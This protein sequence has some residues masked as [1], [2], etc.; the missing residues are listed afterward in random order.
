MTY[1]NGNQHASL[2]PCGPM[3]QAWESDTILLRTNNHQVG[4][5]TMRKE[6]G[7]EVCSWT[8][9]HYDGT[10]F[11]VIQTF[12]GIHLSCRPRVH[13]VLCC[14]LAYLVRHRE[15]WCASSALCMI[16]LNSNMTR[17]WVAGTTAS[18]FAFIVI[19]L[20]C[21]ASPLPS[22]ACQT[23]Y[24]DTGSVKWVEW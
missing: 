14:F 22:L 12:T 5:G 6:R 7:N 21:V 10:I 19:R 2:N 16:I 8:D 23:C 20:F 24:H 1:I 4:I 15:S 9:I 3:S 13:R 18:M 11:D 17:W